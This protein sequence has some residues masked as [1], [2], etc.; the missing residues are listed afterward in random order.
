MSK[1][2]IHYLKSRNSDYL[3]G[4]DLEIFELEGKSKKLTVQDVAYME[5][6]KV[7][8]KIKPKGIVMYFKEP[9]AKPLIVNPTNS[10]IICDQTGIVDITKT[11][12]FTIEFYFNTKVEMRVSKTETIKGGIRIKKVH[13]NGIYAPLE[14]LKTRIE[15]CTSRAE[16]MS[17]WRGINEAD[18]ITHKEQVEVK[19]KDLK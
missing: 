11:I 18:Q 9:Y 19:Y 16:L 2:P 8:G 17:I 15:Q 12:G 6:F 3:A 1:E 5:N 13:T 14:N 7:N 10:R 4:V